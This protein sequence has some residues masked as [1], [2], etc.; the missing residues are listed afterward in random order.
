MCGKFEIKNPQLSIY[1]K[2]PIF[3]KFGKNQNE[4][5]PKIR[6]NCPKVKKFGKNQI[7]IRE[8]SKKVRE[9]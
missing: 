5:I 8:K 6:E 4:I 9:I 1:L 3:K 7:E 2:S